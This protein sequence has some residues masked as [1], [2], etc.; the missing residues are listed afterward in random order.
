MPEHTNVLIGN[1]IPYTEPQEDPVEALR[2][3]LAFSS[4]DWADERDLAWIYGIVCGWGSDPDDPDDDIDCHPELAQ[5]F[6]WDASATARLRRLH[7][8]FE[9]LS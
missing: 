8:R 9:E 2:D 6:G 7:A 4:R 5:R 1:N 3:T